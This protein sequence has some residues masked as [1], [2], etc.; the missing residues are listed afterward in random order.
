M[1]TLKFITS[2]ILAVSCLLASGQVAIAADE[3]PEPDTDGTY[4]MTAGYNPFAGTSRSIIGDDDREIVDSTSTYPYSAIGYLNITFSDGCTAKGTGF[5]VSS[6]C[7]LTAGHCLMCDEHNSDVNSMTIYFGYTTTPSYLKKV[8][9]TTDNAVFYTDPDYTGSEKDYDYGYVVFDSDVGKTTGWFGLAARSNSVLTDMDIIT[10]GYRR[11]I[12]Y[13]CSGVIHSVTTY[14]VKYDTDTEA[15]Q[16]GSP[17]YYYNSTYGYQA[18]AI[19]T[20]G[21]STS[22]EYNS[23]WRITSAFINTLDSLGY[24]DKVE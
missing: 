17:V 20:H 12:L 3:V 23:G 18:V 21:T 16:S 4:V 9:A 6:N 5:M 24:V 8:K 22:E 13:E 11:G 19:H 7:M 14:R 15:G 2:L 1:K 10:A